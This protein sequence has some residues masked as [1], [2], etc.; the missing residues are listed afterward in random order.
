VSEAFAE[1][2]ISDEHILQAGPN[3]DDSRVDILPRSDS[4]VCSSGWPSKTNPDTWAVH[5]STVPADGGILDLQQLEPG[6][7]RDG[8]PGAKKARD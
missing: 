6:I 1:A 8:G 5:Y 2:V 4:T 7:T 3:N